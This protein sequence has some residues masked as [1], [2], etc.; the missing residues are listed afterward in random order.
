MMDM[1][2]NLLQVDPPYMPTL[3]DHL[4]PDVGNVRVLE[5][6]SYFKSASMLFTIN[7]Y[8]YTA[9]SVKVQ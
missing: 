6:Y 4:V 8:L 1:K 7:S 3:T 2:D 9:Y 5:Y